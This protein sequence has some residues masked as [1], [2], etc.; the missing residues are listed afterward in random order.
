M[1]SDVV[2]RLRHPKETFRG[3]LMLVLG[4]LGWCLL[5]FEIVEMVQ[6]GEAQSVAFWAMYAIGFILISLISAALYRAYAFGNQVLLSEQQFPALHRMVVEGAATLGIQKTPRVF[7]YSSHG[8]INAFARR[9]L[10]G[11][12]VF[13]ASGLVDAATDAQLRFVI[14]HEL[15]HH[16][17]GHLDWRKNFVKLPAHFVP[18]LGAAYSRGRELT[19]DRVG[20]LLADDPSAARSALQLLA[21]GCRRLNAE[22]NLDAFE[23]QEKMVP[24]VAGFFG[25]LRAR[26]PRLT[27]RVNEIRRFAAT[28]GRQHRSPADDFDLAAVPK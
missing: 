16:A 13:L 1:V 4:G 8:L 3:N 11:S 15:G 7:L 24:R 9:M 27:V 12:Y 21:C 23:A 10:G 22:M 17:A 25:K 19:C 5:T 28:A 20:A 26:H 18:F 14:G 6:N 2:K